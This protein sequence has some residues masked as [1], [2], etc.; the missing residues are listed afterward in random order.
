MVRAISA[1]DSG[2]VKTV[3]QKTVEDGKYG[4]GIGAT[5]GAVEGYTRKSWITKKNAPTD[6]FVKNISKGL[7]ST[8]KPEETK[9]LEKV[10]MF[11]RQLVNYRTDVHEMRQ[12][13]EKSTELTNA[14]N[15]KKGETTKDALDRI[16][17]NP[18]RLAIKQELRDLQKRTVVDKKVD[19]YKARELAVS[20]IDTKSR[21]LKKSSG[22]SDEVFKVIKAA[23]KKIKVKTA[24][25]HTM[26]GGVLAGT[27]GLLVGAHKMNEHK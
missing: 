13:V 12:R 16:F 5:I 21:T 11:F 17:S 18:D 1:A 15:K 20:N 19:I 8:L 27:V 14:L 10:K 25:Q 9:E 6:T 2:K 7:E 26:V 3:R 23:A 4:L 22:T 24:Y